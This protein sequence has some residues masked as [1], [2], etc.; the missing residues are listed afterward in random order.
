MRSLDDSAAVDSTAADTATSVEAGTNATAAAV[1]SVPVPAAA[2][3]TLPAAGNSSAPSAATNGTG[4]RNGTAP[5]V[6]V[7]TTEIDLLVKQMT[8]PKE[9]VAALLQDIIGEHGT[10]SQVDAARNRWT[11]LI[12]RA[13][14]DMNTAVILKNGLKQ[15]TKA[16]RAGNEDKK[17]AERIA[18]ETAAELQ[19]VN[20]K[21]QEVGDMPPPLPQILE[22]YAV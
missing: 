3:G 10:A 4:N 9:R 6:P 19:S 2:N 13:N 12:D 8:W 1:A 18:R 11:A 17:A 5:A 14:K 21:L 20:E 15:G 7:N 16:L 22:K